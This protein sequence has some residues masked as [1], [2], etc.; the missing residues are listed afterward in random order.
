MEKTLKII[1]HILKE[2]IIKS[3]PI[4]GGVA[5]TYY[6]EPLLTFDLDVFFVPKK[7]GLDVLSPIYDYFKKR[8]YKFQNEQ[9][10]IE[11]IPV[12]FIPVYNELVKDAVEQAVEAKYKR[13]KTK[14]L[15]LEFLMSIAL[16]TDRPKD[17]EK[18]IRLIDEAKINKKLLEAI[19]KKH[20]LCEKYQKFKGRYYD[21]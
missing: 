19:L 5:A 13:L 4:G 8:G 14:I 15:R 18:V 1:N 7:E 16:Q 11:G 17:R 10:L 2:G 9:I 6:I 20:K 3:Y 12:Q 21:S